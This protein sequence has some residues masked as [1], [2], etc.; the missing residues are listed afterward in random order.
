M[1]FMDQIRLTEDMDSTV[2]HIDLQTWL[3]VYLRKRNNKIFQDLEG[4]P[5]S[6]KIITEE[7]DRIGWAHFAEGRMMKRIRDM[8]T[9]YMCNRGLTH[10]ED[11]W[12]RDL[13]EN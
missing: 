7:Q 4:L 1:V 2:T 3:I 9:M 12:M 11:H 6:M 8:Q 5:R 13:I 10:T